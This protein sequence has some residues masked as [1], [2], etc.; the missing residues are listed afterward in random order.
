M[1]GK[2]L[3]NSIR[4]AA[5]LYAIIVAHPVLAAFDPTGSFASKSTLPTVAPDVYIFQIIFYVLGLLAAITLAL[6]IYSGLMIMTAAGSEERVQ[7][8]MATLR[9]TIIGLLIIMSSWG[10]ILFF[11]NFLVSLG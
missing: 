9:W 1:R 4:I 3:T 7:K 8:G 10:I 6:I 11:N 5:T 2:P